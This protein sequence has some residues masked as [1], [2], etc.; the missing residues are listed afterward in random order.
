MNTKW[1]SFLLVLVRMAHAAPGSPASSGL[2]NDF[3]HPPASARPWV[4]WYWVNGNTSRRGITADL[5]AMQRV[6]IGGVLI[7]DATLN[8][9]VGP[10]PFGSQEWRDQVK[11]AIAEASRLGLE[12]NL[13][14]AAG[15][16]G[17]GGPWIT[18]ELGQKLVAWTETQFIGGKKFSG[19]LP[20]PRTYANWF[21]DTA[22]LAIP[23]PE[24]DDVTLASVSPR[25]TVNRD[26][27]EF[28]AQK[29]ID[30]NP[31]TS[32]VLPIPTET[33]PRFILIE[34]PRPYLARNL[35]LSLLEP[36]GE[37]LPGGAAIVDGVLQ[38]SDDGKDFRDVCHLNI[39][40]R[41]NLTPCDFETSFDGVTARW[42]RILFTN[43]SP[44]VN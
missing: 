28:D 26:G 25:I 33:R 11:F 31:D 34:F 17:S 39:T 16:C 3:I 12:V 8:T 1:I 2:E 14:N 44:R 29:L 24:G 37:G 19:N 10:A 30:G 21:R 27:K 4:Y 35:A 9:P 38:V 13:A 42:F 32:V 23:T 41:A 15:W 20:R 40:T 36:Q 7:M 22:V 5:E 18:P 6:G 43:V